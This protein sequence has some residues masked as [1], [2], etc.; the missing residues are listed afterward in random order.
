MNMTKMVI[1]AATSADLP[2][3][4]GFEQGVITAERPFAANLKDEHITY[5]DLQQLIASDDVLL[6][7]A[8]INEQLVAAGY[9][10]I[11]PSKTYKK[12][13]HHAYL[14]FMYVDPRSRGQGINKMIIDELTLWAKAKGIEEMILDVY[15]DNEAAISAYE[16]VGFKKN[17]VEMRVEI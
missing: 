9:A 15:N 4:L 16:K 13:S 8:E 6:V 14:G 2:T 7:V 3:L 1:R 5:Y 11:L 10:K 12:Y 17:L